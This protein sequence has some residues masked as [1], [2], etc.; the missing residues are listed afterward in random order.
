[1]CDILQ[2]S[3]EIFF[4]WRIFGSLPLQYTLCTPYFAYQGRHLWQCNYWVPLWKTGY[5]FYLLLQKTDEALSSQRET[6]WGMAASLNLACFPSLL[7]FPQWSTTSIPRHSEAAWWIKLLAAW[8]QTPL[9]GARWFV[10][11]LLT[12]T[13]ALKSPVCHVNI[14]QHNPTEAKGSKISYTLPS[15]ARWVSDGKAG[16]YGWIAPSMDRGV[17]LSLHL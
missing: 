2:R 16:A 6:I 17:M 4:L 12:A 10:E 7:S 1:M 15:D 9:F 11:R 14:C 8:C 3:A 5:H 13:V